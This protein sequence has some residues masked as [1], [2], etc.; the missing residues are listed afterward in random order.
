MVHRTFL[1]KHPKIGDYDCIIKQAIENA[2]SVKAN[3]NKPDLLI[4]KKDA[5]TL[6]KAPLTA[7]SSSA[8]LGITF[9]LDDR[10]LVTPSKH[11]KEVF[12]CYKDNLLVLFGNEEIQ[13]L[14]EII[15][16]SHS[17]AIYY[18]NLPLVVSF[19]FS[20]LFNKITFYVFIRGILF[21]TFFY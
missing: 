17:F 18:G 16:N 3:T 13:W 7:Y 4:S 14:Q 15:Q 2:I 19:L 8:H 12:Q 20:P 10:N 6:I 21:V 9:D 5:L 1:M 11:K